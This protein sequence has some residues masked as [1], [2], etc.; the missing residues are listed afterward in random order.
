MYTF[1]HAV[2]YEGGI[3][4]KVVCMIKMLVKRELIDHFQGGLL[5]VIYFFIFRR[6]YCHLEGL[7]ILAT[8]HLYTTTVSRK[9]C[10]FKFLTAKCSI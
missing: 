7:H 4:D 10:F 1:W 3:Q 6:K 5:E 8:C 9:F 2:S